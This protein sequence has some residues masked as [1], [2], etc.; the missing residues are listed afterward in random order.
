MLHV[1]G[2]T[3]RSLTFQ[4]Q[5]IKFLNPVQHNLA[6]SRE[7]GGP[8]P[9]VNPR[10]CVIRSQNSKWRGILWTYLIACMQSCPGLFK[11]KPVPKVAF[12]FSKEV[13]ILH[14]PVAVAALDDEK[15]TWDCHPSQSMHGFFRL[16]NPKAKVKKK[17]AVG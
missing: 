16:L 14:R 9:Q 17:F 13:V 6:A 4:P 3:T 1:S 5:S 7:A 2:H 11:C 8:L 12:E 15:A 10:P